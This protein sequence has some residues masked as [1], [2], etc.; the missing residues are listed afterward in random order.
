MHSLCVGYFTGKAFSYIT[1]QCHS[2]LFAHARPT[3][4]YIP[5][6]IYTIVCGQINSLHTEVLYTFQC[7][8]VEIACNQRCDSEGQVDKCASVSV[9]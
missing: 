7:S 1:V 4:F 6:S 8:N 9:A 2:G 3:M 5:P